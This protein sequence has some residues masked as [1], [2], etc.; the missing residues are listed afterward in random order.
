MDVFVVFASSVIS[1]EYFRNS[2]VVF[3]SGCDSKTSTTVTVSET[4]VHPSDAAATSSSKHL[5]D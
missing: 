3:G 5:D 2:A 4:F 1:C